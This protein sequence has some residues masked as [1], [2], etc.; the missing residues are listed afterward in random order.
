[1]P[2]PDFFGYLRAARKQKQEEFTQQMKVAAFTG[3]QITTL[4]TSILGSGSKQQPKQP[5]FIEYA[6]GLGVLSEN[7]KEYLK[8]MKEY[9]K[10][11]AKTEAKRNIEKAENIIQMFKEDGSRRSVKGR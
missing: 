11:Q 5:S 2:I 10:I 4:I 7:E 6:E 3:W 9:E 1:M 8:I